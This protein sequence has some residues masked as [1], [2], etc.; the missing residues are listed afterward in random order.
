VGRTVIIGDV[1][2]CAD[3]LEELLAA[4]GLGSEDRLVTVG[5]LVARGPDSRRVL[6]LV[7]DLDATGVRGNHEVR[8][9][10]AREARR[11]GVAGP[12]LGPSH[13][14]LVELLDDADWAVLDRLPAYLELP[15]HGALVVH[16][17]LVPGKPI[18]EQ[19][20]WA[21][22][23]IRSLDEAGAP[24]DRPGCQSWAATYQGEAHVVFGHDARRGLQ[25]YAAATGLDSACIYGGRLSALVLAEGAAVPPASDRMDAIVSVPARR[26]YITG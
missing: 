6:R 5:D 1:H 12:P 3:E 16:A 19:D 14:R 10:A 24:S 18:T 25:L 23:H 9:L 8:L 20:P 17:G 13:A 21:L 15:A 26:A 22:T 7:R 2:G 4:V 11:R